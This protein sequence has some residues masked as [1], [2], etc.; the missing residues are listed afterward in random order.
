MSFPKPFSGNGGRSPGPHSEPNGAPKVACFVSPHGF[1]HA[2]RAAAVMSAIHRRHNDVRFEIFTTVPGWFFESSLKAPFNLHPVETDVGFVQV[3]PFVQDLARTRR[4]LDRFLPLD[5]RRVGVLAG[6]L[7]DLNCTLAIC[8]ISPLGI[9]AGRAAGLPTVL[10]ENFTWDWLYEGYLRFAQTIQP[11][12]DYLRRIFETV[13]VHI[14]TEPLCDRKENRALVGPVS[15][16]PRSERRQ[17][18]RRL[19][20]PPGEKMVLITTGGVPERCA[21]LDALAARPEAVF[22]IPG[23]AEGVER[24]GNLIRLPV[25][26]EF[27][28]PDLVA[29]GDA[30]VGKAGYSTLAEV[31]AAGVPFGCVRRSDFRE[32]GALADFVRREMDAVDIELAAFYNGDWLR[33]LP[34]LLALP[35]RPGPRTNGA[36]QIAQLLSGYIQRPSKRLDP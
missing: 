29:A 9:V 10:V 21:F 15:R 6:R 2:A 31:W 25:N 22:V 24:R 3:S 17:V 12:I 18:R 36:E 28:H 20:I 33:R 11:H 14:Q 5:D 1:G 4:R 30:V 35:R 7:R 19:G 34:E 27:F 32:S 16:E 23:G 8:D 26:S 13:E